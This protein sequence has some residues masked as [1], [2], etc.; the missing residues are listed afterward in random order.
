MIRSKPAALAVLLLAASPAAHA[1]QT[2]TARDGD[3]VLA[4]IAQKEI[5]RIAVDRGRIRK[6]TGNAGEFHLEKDEQQGEIY[7]RPADPSSTKPINVFVTSERGTVGLLL[8]PVDAPSETIL[9]RKLSDT[10]ARPT[11]EASAPRHIRTLKHLLFSLATDTPA[12]G[13]EVRDAKLE[14]ALWPGLRMTLQRSHLADQIVGEKYQVMNMAATPTRLDA[15]DLYKPGVMAVSVE[16][17]EIAPG[18]TTHV[19]VLRERHAHE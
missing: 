1:L 2:L 9:I 18:H 13:M 4:K 12:D 3:T 7:L 14:V 8:Q 19:F 11:R 16:G 5:T 17:D 10:A 6:V 15:M